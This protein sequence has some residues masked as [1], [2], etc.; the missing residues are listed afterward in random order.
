MRVT[1]IY[2]GILDYYK[3]LG[4]VG[5]GKTNLI[6]EEVIDLAMSW[7]YFDGVFLEDHLIYGGGGCL[8]FSTTHYFILKSGL[9][10]GTNNF[11]ELLALKFL[12]L[13]FVEKGFKTLQVFCDSMIII[14]WE[15]GVQRCHI[16][17]LVPIYEEVLRIITVFYSISFTHLYR[18][19]NQLAD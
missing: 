14:N 5:L 4:G 1:S 12:L 13:F 19:R 15:N 11:V 8:Y 16:S 3:N 7:D 9:G 10:A 17:R 2:L 18:E 6:R